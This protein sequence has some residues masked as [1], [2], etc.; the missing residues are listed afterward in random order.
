[1]QALL[2]ERVGQRAYDMLLANQLGK[3]LGTPLA[4]E[5]LAHLNKPSERTER[6]GTTDFMT[7]GALPFHPREALIMGFIESKL[8]LK[9]GIYKGA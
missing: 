4:G 5:D 1:M 8:P 6:K 7:S 9:W 3:R 2:C